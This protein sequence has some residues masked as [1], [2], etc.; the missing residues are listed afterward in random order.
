MIDI[1]PGLDSRL[2]S[3]YERIEDERPRRGF[4]S[5]EVTRP[6]PHLR[7]LH[8]VAGMAGVAIVAAGVGR[9]RNRAGGPSQRQT[10]SAGIDVRCSRPSHS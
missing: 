4:E 3:F 6:R 7:A 9:L 1:D 5:F 10:T 8:F 2:R